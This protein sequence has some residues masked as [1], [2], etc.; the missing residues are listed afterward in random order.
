MRALRLLTLSDLEEL[1][2]LRGEARMVLAAI[3]ATD[4]AAPAENNELVRPAMRQGLVRAFECDSSGYPVGRSWVAWV[5]AFLAMLGTLI[6]RRTVQ[7]VSRLLSDVGGVPNDWE[8]GGDVDRVIWNLLVNGV[9]G[10]MA[11]LTS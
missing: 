11:C 4:E 7:Q 3:T 5:P 8:V 2:I 1:G 10:G 9:I 6:S